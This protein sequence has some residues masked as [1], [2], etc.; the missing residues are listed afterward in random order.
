MGSAH[1]HDRHDPPDRTSIYV[2]RRLA[3]ATA[4][5]LIAT[6]LGLVLLWPEPAEISAGSQGGDTRRF[7]ATVVEVSDALCGEIAQGDA[8]RCYE[9]KA[10][11]DDG[12][13]AGE[14]L[15]F[16]YAGGKGSRVFEDGDGILLGHSPDS[17]GA[18]SPSPGQPEYF[19][20]DYQRTG[21]LLI[22]G[23]M[24]AIVVTV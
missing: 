17:A 6:V 16:P 3:L 13:D 5:F 2:Q 11:L 15:T 9:V 18:G 24:F 4:P 20:V 14:T 8:F 19:F 23:A 7:S 1:T 21:P 22:L 12:P 10:R